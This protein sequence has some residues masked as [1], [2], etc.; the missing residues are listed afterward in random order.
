MPIME[1]KVIIPKDIRGKILGSNFLEPI[2]Q[3]I[4]LPAKIMWDNAVE[5]LVVIIFK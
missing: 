5:Y 4:P 2:K 1:F 3:Y